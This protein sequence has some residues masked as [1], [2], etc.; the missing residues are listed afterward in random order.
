MFRVRKCNRRY[1]VISVLTTLPLLCLSA[2][3][4]TNILSDDLE[5]HLKV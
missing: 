3:F 2:H 4:Y 5:N 1:V